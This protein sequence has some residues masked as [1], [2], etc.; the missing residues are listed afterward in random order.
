VGPKSLR[1]RFITDLYRA[2][3]LHPGSLKL[4]R[5]RDAGDAR[6]KKTKHSIVSVLSW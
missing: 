3:L 6:W 2:Y 1:V 5:A 4:A